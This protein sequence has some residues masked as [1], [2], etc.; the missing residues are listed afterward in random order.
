METLDTECRN[1]HCHQDAI[2]PFVADGRWSEDTMF[3]VF[4]SDWRLYP[5]GKEPADVK[6]RL[7]ERF[8]RS[9]LELVGSTK[10]EIKEFELGRH[11]KVMCKEIFETCFLRSKGHANRSGHGVLDC[12]MDIMMMLTLAARNGCGDLVWWSWVPD[13]QKQR[14]QPS[15]GAMFISIVPCAARKILS[16]MEMKTFAAKPNHWD[17]VLLQWLRKNQVAVKYSHFLPSMGSYVTHRSGCSPK[18]DTPEGRPSEFHENYNAF[19]TRPGEDDRG[20]AKW[21]CRLVAKGCAEHKLQVVLP[22]CGR[23][24]INPILWYTFD[25][26]DCEPTATAVSVYQQAQSQH[27]LCGMD[28][29]G[30]LEDAPDSS[31][32][33]GPFP[34]S[35]NSVTNASDYKSDANARSSDVKKAKTDRNLRRVRSGNAFQR[36]RQWIANPEQA[37]SG[38]SVREHESRYE[39]DE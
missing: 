18:Y 8:T 37:G 32:R 23:D 29:S 7:S 13:K 21:F 17:V 3:F 11:D 14:T 25:D 10:K 27:R 15:H 30:M 9:D 2:L 33:M 28:G 31:D 38:K 36:M 24:F 6:K 5:P 4:E 34:W 39:R 1:M 26:T 22:E 16:A 35:R 12:W 19:G 20:R